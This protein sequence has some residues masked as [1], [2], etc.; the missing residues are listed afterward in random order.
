MLQMVLLPPLLSCI[1]LPALS[2]KFKLVN[3]S[4]Q[5][6]QLQLIKSLQ[7]LHLDPDSSQPVACVWVGLGLLV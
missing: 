3:L 5:K 2:L 7:P 6:L 4:S 1:L